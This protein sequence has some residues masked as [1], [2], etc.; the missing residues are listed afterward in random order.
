MYIFKNTA[1]I[2]RNQHAK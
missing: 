1:D 2:L